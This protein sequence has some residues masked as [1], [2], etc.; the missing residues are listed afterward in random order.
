MDANDYDPY[1]QYNLPNEPGIP[2]NW[3]PMPRENQ[4]KISLSADISALVDRYPDSSLIGHAQYEKEKESLYAG[5]I[6]LLFD[7]SEDV[8]KI[9]EMFKNEYLQS[10]KGY[11][12][13]VDEVIPKKVVDSFKRIFEN[14]NAY[15]CA[16][17]P[18][19]TPIGASTDLF[20]G[21]PGLIFIPDDSR[22]AKSF[23]LETE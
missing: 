10:S 8:I 23:A 14:E 2:T 7:K 11:R 6:S 4:L 16:Y 19:Y 22:L 21:K 12:P 20:G 13:T 17:F 15:P 5:I 3:K 1:A 9:R 18:A